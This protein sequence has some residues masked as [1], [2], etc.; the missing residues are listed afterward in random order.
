MYEIVFLDFVHRLNYKEN[1]H[2]SE[3]GFCLRLQVKGGKEEKLY[4]L[5]LLVELDQVKV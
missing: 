3:A 1:H 2:V 4:L 5:G